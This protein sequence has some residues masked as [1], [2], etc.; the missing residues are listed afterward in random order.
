[1]SEVND[2]G[3]DFGISDEEVA[4]LQEQQPQE[5]EPQTEAPAEQPPAQEPEPQ[6]PES[7]EERQSHNV[8]LTALLDEREKR[9]K[10]ER[11]L[12]Q[13]RQQVPQQPQQ[14]P[15]VPDPYEDP[16]GYQQY[17]QAQIDDRTFKAT[18]EIS[19]RFAEQKY[20]K[21]AVEEAVRWAQEQGAK[22][23]TL[24]QR[25]RISNDPVG[26]IVEQFQREQFWQ[27]YQSDPSILTQAT[28]QTAA[29][30]MAAPAVTKPIAPPRSLAAAPGAGGGH[31]SIPDGS[32]L[33]SVKFN[34]D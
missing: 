3:P 33:D 32:V 20:G 26:F 12:E 8:P 16:A 7:T 13:M 27:K 9:Q 25:V 1:M 14:A 18:A 29:P 2:F 24:G 10:L 30:Q 4:A 6:Q 11:E 31:Q 23:P 21:E 15:Q 28:T 22:D 5:A 17:I 19:G 34:L